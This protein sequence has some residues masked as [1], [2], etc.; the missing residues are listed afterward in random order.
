MVDPNHCEP[1]PGQAP[2]SEYLGPGCNGWFEG[3][4]LLLIFAHRRMW[5]RDTPPG[6]PATS[7]FRDYE[8]SCDW[9]AL[10][11]PEEL[12]AQRPEF[13]IAALTVAQCISRKQ[14]IK[15]S[16]V[17]HHKTLSDNPAHCDIIG[18]KTGGPGGSLSNARWLANHCKVLHEPHPTGPEAPDG[19]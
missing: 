15:Y 1:A 4:E 7:I 5:N 10:K 2:N 14:T 6:R 11:S 18:E 16:P 12:L 3:H 17:R 19:G 8:T 13:G 9:E